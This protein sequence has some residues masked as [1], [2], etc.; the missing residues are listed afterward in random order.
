MVRTLLA[1]SRVDVNAKDPKGAGAAHA[2][3]KLK[4]KD[5]VD[6]VKLLLNSDRSVDFKAQDSEGRT[7][8]YHACAFNQLE[9]IQLLTSTPTARWTC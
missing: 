4:G 9:L 5:G 6:I 3:C 2:A 7:P 1:S 8:F